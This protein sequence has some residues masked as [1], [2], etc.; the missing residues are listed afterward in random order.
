MTRVFSFPPIA[1]KHAER[2]VLGSMPGKASLRADQYYA[3]P[4]N[5]FWPIIDALFG[6]AVDLS[7][8]QRCARVVQ[9][10]LAVWDVLKTCRRASS[11]DSDIVPDSIE[12]HDFAAFFTAHPA[13]RVIFFNGTMAEQSFRRHVLAG[14]PSAAAAIPRIR[15]PSTSP[16]NAA[17]SFE[18]K[19]DRWRQLR[20]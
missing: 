9:E 11:L 15:L 14:L 17:F 13:I 20:V 3:H 19:L 12:P 2:L 6:I 8:E 4:R 18:Q 10:R 7:Y 5:A 16:A 1:D